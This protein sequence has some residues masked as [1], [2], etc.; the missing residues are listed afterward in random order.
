MNKTETTTAYRVWARI[1]SEEKQTLAY[2]EDKKEARLWLNK[3][4]LEHDESRGDE[5]IG[6][7][8]EPITI[9]LKENK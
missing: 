3:Y 9:Y 1:L 6:E 7:G 4:C 2:F 5:Y 8:I